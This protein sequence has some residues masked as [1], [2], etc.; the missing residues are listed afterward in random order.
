MN[1]VKV[2]AKQTSNWGLLFG[3]LLFIACSIYLFLNANQ[4]NSPQ[5]AKVLSGI[6]F[7][8]SLLFIIISIKKLMKKQ[9]ILLIDK[10]GIVYKPTD[11][12]NYIEWEK[13]LE[14]EELK[15]PRQRVINIKVVDA[16]KFIN[17]ESQK[18][19]QVRMRFWNKMYGAVVSFDAN[20]LDKNHFE[21]MNLFDEFMEDYKISTVSKND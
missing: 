16:D 11:Q 4:V 13:I 18:F 3:S 9:L 5:T 1:S 14:I 12:L 10:K 19:L 20:T 21:I 15:L 2:Y 8:P 7:I 6:L 17:N